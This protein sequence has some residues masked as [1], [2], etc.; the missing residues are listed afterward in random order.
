M[1]I[2]EIKCKLDNI[3]YFLE[4]NSTGQFT[5]TQR[6]F[7]TLSNLR[8]E[9]DRICTP[10]WELRAIQQNILMLQNRISSIPSNQGTLH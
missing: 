10:T 1:D 4:N 2:A 7:S 3:F 9:C 6:I 5:D 8:I